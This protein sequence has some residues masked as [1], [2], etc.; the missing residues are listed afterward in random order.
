MEFKSKSVFKIKEGI[1]LFLLESSQ[2]KH[3]L[4]KDKKPVFIF[5]LKDKNNKFHDKF[6]F[7][8]NGKDD[9]FPDLKSDIFKEKIL[10][11]MIDPFFMTNL[12]N[13]W[14]EYFL[15]KFKNQFFK[16]SIDSVSHVCLVNICDEIFNGRKRS[17]FL[18]KWILKLINSLLLNLQNSFNSKKTPS[19][20]LADEKKIFMARDILIEESVSPPG[21]K[22]LAK[23]CSINENKLKTGFKIIFG[24]PPKSFL[25]RHKMENAK[26]FIEEKGLSITEAALNSGY[27]NPSAFSAV[28]QKFH[29]FP[30]SH[31]KKTD[32]N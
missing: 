21:I 6:L 19:I 22:E 31:F 9:D 28:F 23:R 20:T 8:F 4:G 29:G 15:S 27:S 5:N 16:G 3:V 14:E 11:L 30:P 32:V 2:L 7:Y 26:I 18:R 25:R 24:E 1:E 17:V 13:S 12:S 10:I